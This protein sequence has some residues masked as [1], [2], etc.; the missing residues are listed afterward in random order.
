MLQRNIQI[1][2]RKGFLLPPNT[3]LR[4][5]Q[6][7][8][9]INM[10][11]INRIKELVELLNKASDAYY[12]SGNTIMSDEEFD[13]KLEELKI[14][15]TEIGLILSNSPTHN[16]GAKVLSKQNKVI[17][18]IPMLSLDKLH[19][20]EELSKWAGDDDC[21]LSLKLD[22]LSTRLVF[23]NGILI[24]AST[25]GDGE[26]GSDILEH[27]KCY[28]NV[29]TIISYK[30][31]LVIDGES[32]ILYDDFNRINSELPKDKQ[33]ANARNLASGTLSNLD[34]SVT[35]TRHMKFVAWRIIDGF[36]IINDSNFFKLKEA[37]KIGFEIVP[38]WTY[39]NKADKDNLSD[40]LHNLRKQA[41][42][43]GIP[44]DGVVM[45]KDSIRLSKQMG[46]TSKF[47]RHSISY[48]FEDEVYKTKLIDIEWTMGK[49]G[50]LTPT[51]IFQPTI[52]DGTTV[53]R[54]SL[55][56]I[57]IIKKLGLSNNCTVF[58]KKANCIIPQITKALQDG[59]SDIILPK[60]CPVCGGNTEVMKE[61]ES[62][63]LMCTNPQCS[64]KLLGR[65]KFF[66]SKPAVNIDGL[67]EATLEFLIDKGWVK[68]FRDIYHLID[69]KNLLE[70]CS[71]FGKKSV[72]NLLKAIEDSRNITL[73]RF[74]C[75][76][77]ID[78]IGKSA[79]KTLST[80]F[81][82][83]FYGF[84]EAFDIGFN[85]TILDDIGD[86]TAQNINEYLEK[87]HVEIYILAQEFN[88]ILPKKV[89]VKENPLNGIKFC[90]TGSFSQSRDSLKEQLEAKGAKF[91]SSVSKNLDILFCGEKAGSKLI[92]AQGLGVRVV[93]EDE[94]MK[95]LID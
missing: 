36:E 39:T 12:N 57:S 5:I 56:N 82:G 75:A 44:I 24:E 88:F 17:H 49:T 64:G 19:T 94:L 61:N 2:Q 77:S 10:D 20:V 81:N 58:V 42:N 72:D 52:I 95:M 50:C 89:E 26:T 66:V 73:D 23:E 9:S 91:V 83:D 46:R 41:N 18:E 65:L 59:D 87:N 16:V 28:D 76:L 68:S 30:D 34:T 4:R 22:G 93:Y 80:Y 33:F 21:Y 86:K 25:R 60:Y 53:E 11:K 74:I 6:N 27:I 92:K 31:R 32:L 69:Y 35:K 43:K 51:A 3:V 85:W 15:E 79:A 47:F 71:G 67:S 37:E 13:A 45:A 63:V 90:I 40:M 55:T 14:L 84:L 8:W 38:I 29:P 1:G 54:A 78:G 62:E 7:D 70:K 48:K